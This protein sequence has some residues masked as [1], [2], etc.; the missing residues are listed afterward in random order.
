MNRWDKVGLGLDFGTES[1]RAVLVD[2]AGAE[3]GGAVVRYARGQICDRLPG[4]GEPLPPDF[5]LQDPDDWLAGAGQAVRQALARS[6]LDPRAVLGIGVDFT[7][8]TVLPTRADGT[9]LCRVPAL[10]GDPHAW[11]KLWKHHG[12][13]RQTD[14]LNAVARDRDEPFLRRYGGIIGLEWFFPKILEVI[15]GAPGVADAAEAWLEAG[16]WLVWR[17]VGGPAGDLPRSTCQAGYKGMWNATDGF[18]PADYLAAVHPDLAGVL[19]TKLPGR[20]VPP[21]VAAGELCPAAAEALGLVPGIPVSAAIIDA[22]AAVPGVGAAEPGTLVLVLG[23]SA[24]HMLNAAEERFVP[25][26]AGVVKDGILPG[27]YGYETGQ[28]AFGDA[29]DWLRG[30]VGHDGFDRLDRAAAA[31]PPGAD[32]VHC[33]DWFNGCRTPLMDGSLTGAFGGL[34]LRHGPGHLYRALME[35]SACGLRWIVD[36]LAD[37]G[38]PVDRL[39]ATGGLPHH[40]PLIVRVIADVLGR[41]VEVHPSVHGTARGA[42]ILGVLAAGPAASGFASV[43]SAVRT[44]GAPPDLA[45]TRVDPDRA[46]QAVSQQ[47]Y[48]RYRRWADSTARP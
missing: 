31:I 10:A 34:T 19:A 11:P 9:P 38:V 15:E 28:A 14:R 2:L 29:F 4:T 26:V 27:L 16:D 25:G 43:E 5:A 42:A 40:N 48:S 13:K 7:S 32:G 6:R 12:A 8:C 20:M 46:A 22:H 39:V 30:L 36:L 35:A 21:G 24:C 17:L 1:V 18:P 23:T 37:R 47:V 45:T 41:P 33:L 44:M 3:R